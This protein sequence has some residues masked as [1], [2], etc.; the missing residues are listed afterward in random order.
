MKA[1]PGRAHQYRRVRMGKG[2]DYV[3]Y[4]CILPGC[5]HYINKELAPGRESICWE[6]GK[7][8]FM[9][10]RSLQQAKPTCGCKSFRAERLAG[11]DVDALLKG[12]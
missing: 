7:T 2:K 9:T 11:L 4:R 1:H 10:T 5:S 12:K 8:F 6:C 3:V